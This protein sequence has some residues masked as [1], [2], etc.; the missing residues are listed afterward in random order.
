MKDIGHGRMGD[1]RYNVQASGWRD[2]IHYP[3]AAHQLQVRSSRLER[4]RAPRSP[5]AP[6][7]RPPPAPTLPPPPPPPPRRGEVLPMANEG[8]LYR[9]NPVP[10]D[11][12]EWQRRRRQHCRPRVRIAVTG[13]E[14]FEKLRH[15]QS[16]SKIHRVRRPFRESSRGKRR[17]VGA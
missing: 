13:P 15:V 4:C 1:V 9:P 8:L 5:R 12:G 16:T 6:P 11:G 7:V 17:K 2:Q 3:G 14:D 10:A